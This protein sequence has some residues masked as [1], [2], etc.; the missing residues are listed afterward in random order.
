METWVYF[1]VFAAFFQNIRSVIQ[2]NLLHQLDVLASSYVRFLYAL[3]ICIVVSSILQ[4]MTGVEVPT[5]NF[6][7]A[8]FSI[9]GG[10]AQ[11]FATV[12]LI[13]LFTLKKF[14]V[15]GAFKKTEALISVGIGFLILQDT[16]SLYGFFAIL[17]GIL[18]IMMLSKTRLDEGFI[19]A[20][21]LVGLLCG[22]MFS[23]SA[24]FYRGA[25]LALDFGEFYLRAI[26][27]LNY[28]LLY[29]A[30]FF[31]LILFFYNRGILLSALHHWRTGWLAGLSGLLA[32]FGWFSAMNLAHVSY[33][34]AVGQIELLFA[35]G[36][37]FIFFKET[38]SLKEFLG[39]FLIG[40]SI[41]L[42]IL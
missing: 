10:T 11:V 40:L 34:K 17:T 7:F 36:A 5:V 21:S 1:A 13:Y 26:V 32:S 3:P 20:G 35:I 39:I 16:V 24:V 18:G 30:L 14:A 8:L 4:I 2:K 28:V 41:V 29:Q 38:L 12:L 25:T 23:F 31:G 42:L 22:L 33:V 19:N 6:K 37:G 9:L 27:T 15:G